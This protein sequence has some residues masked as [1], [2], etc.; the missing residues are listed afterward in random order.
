M[1]K[2]RITI[3][4]FV[5]CA[6]LVMGVGYAAVSGQ[7]SI[8]GSATYNGTSEVASDVNTAV[9]FADEADQVYNASNCTAKIDGADNATMIVTFNDTVGAPNT[10]FTATATFKVL[11]EAGDAPLPTIQ[12]EA[13]VLN[14]NNTSAGFQYTTSWDST[15]PALSAGNSTEVTVTITY[16]TPDEN[17]PTGSITSTFVLPLKYT[18]AS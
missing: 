10:T 17:V 6:A 16:T 8:T 4:A 11:Y 1:K 7:L 18:T 5:L 13:P 15:Q 2:R 9:R 12:M 3:V 14:F